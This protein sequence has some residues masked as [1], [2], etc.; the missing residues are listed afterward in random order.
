M[1][2]TVA[3]INLITSCHKMYVAIYQSCVCGGLMSYW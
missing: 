3:D 2:K 1:L